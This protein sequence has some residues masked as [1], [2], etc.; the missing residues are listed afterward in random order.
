MDLYFKNEKYQEILDA[1]DQL[2][3]K[4]L[5]ETKFPREAVVLTTGACYKLVSFKSGPIML[6]VTNIDYTFIIYYI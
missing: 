4:K 5:A 3:V 2:Q 6:F 1:F